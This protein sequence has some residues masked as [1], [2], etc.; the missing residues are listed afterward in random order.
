MIEY[1][2]RVYNDGNNMF[3]YRNGKAHCEHG[4]AKQYANGEKSWWLNGEILTEAKFN[5]RMNKPCSGK[6]VDIKC[7]KYKLVEVV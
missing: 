3:W 7:V 5:K 6:I 4:P 2:V 1:K